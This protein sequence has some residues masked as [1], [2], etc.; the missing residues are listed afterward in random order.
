MD[1]KLKLIIIHTLIDHRVYKQVDLQDKLKISKKRLQEIVEQLNAELMPYDSCIDFDKFTK[2]YMLTSKNKEMLKSYYRRL[3]ANQWSWTSAN[4]IWYLSV[5]LLSEAKCVKI[6]TLADELF[7]SQR[8]ISSDMAVVR[9]QLEKY[10]LKIKT[11]PHYGMFV[12]GSEL[13]KRYCLIEYYQDD[14]FNSGILLLNPKALEDLGFIRHSVSAILKKEDFLITDIA[15]ESLIINLY[16][17]VDRIRKD[18]LI[19]NI[20]ENIEETTETKVAK[21]IVSNL[22]ERFSIT[23]KPSEINYIAVQLKG[24][25]NYNSDYSN[26][27]APEIG[28]LV[29]DFLTRV[30]QKNK[31]RLRNNFDLCKTLELHFAALIDRIKYGLPQKNLMLEEIKQKYFYEFELA[32]DGCEVINERY[33]ARVSEDEIGFIALEIRAANEKQ[34]HHE[35]Y[36]ILLVCATGRGS[37]QL[38][39]LKLEETFGKR[40]DAIEQCSSWEAEIINLDQYDYILTTVPLLTKTETPILRIPHFLDNR[41]LAEIFE[42]FNTYKAKKVAPKYFK[43]ELF[44]PRMQA[45]NRDEALKKMVDLIGKYYDIPDNFYSLVLQREGRAKT[46]FGNRVAVPHPDELVTKE[47]FACVAT[48]EQPILWDEQDKVSVIILISI[49]NNPHRDLKNFYEVLSFLTNYEYNVERLLEEPSYE[50]LLKILGE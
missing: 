17:S 1:E 19:E 20:V 8:L 2:S 6:E 41:A 38:L 28:D 18:C 24:K 3:Q 5:R 25:K 9:K 16:I 44:I 29:V 13:R 14:N 50:M 34:R 12:E 46:S 42:I 32:M 35:R 21:M 10:D 43:P 26:D 47:T 11:I 27:I 15:F 33:H 39:R 48:L 7:V 45:Q 4:R 40:I 22:S 23:F 30:D 37:A 36:R 49:E 31:T